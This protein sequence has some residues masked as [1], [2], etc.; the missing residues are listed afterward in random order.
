MVINLTMVLQEFINLTLKGGDMRRVLDRIRTMKH[1]EHLIAI[2]LLVVFYFVERA[3]HD[4][5][6]GKKH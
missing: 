4:M 5:V 3:L 2:P 1:G 6:F